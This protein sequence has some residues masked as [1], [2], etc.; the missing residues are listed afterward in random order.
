MLGHS[1]KYLERFTEI[2]NPGRREDDISHYIEKQ[3]D[4]SGGTLFLIQPSAS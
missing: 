4:K 1:C 3:M 2:A